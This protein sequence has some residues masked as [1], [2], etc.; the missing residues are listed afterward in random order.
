MLR[1]ISVPTLLIG[2]LAAPALPQESGSKDQK[3]V[4]PTKID[5]SI[6]KSWNGGTG[7]WNTGADWTPTGAPNNGGGNTYNVI[8]GTT[9]DTVSLDLNATISSLILGGASGLSILQNLANTTESLTING[10]LTINSTGQ[11]LCIVI[12]RW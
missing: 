9:S 7:T 5:A 2:L 3:K 4:R 1:S 8:I 11:S 6:N 12:R 10:P